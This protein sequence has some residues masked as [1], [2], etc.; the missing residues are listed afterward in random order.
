MLST[1]AFNALLKVLEEPPAHVVFILATTELHKIPATIISRCQRFD[2]RRVPLADIADH[3]TDICQKEKVQCEPEVITAI[4]KNSEGYL[5]DA[6][7][8]LGQILSLG[9]TKI[10]REHADLVLPHSHADLVLQFVATLVRRQAAEAIAL[11]DR[12]VQDGVNVPQFT[13]DTVELL[14]QILVAKITN[15]F[16]TAGMEFTRDEQRVLEDIFGQVSVE[17]LV[18]MIDTLLARSALFKT[19]PI[20]QLPLELAA[21]ELCTESQSNQP[22]AP[23][24]LPPPP[25]AK[26]ETTAVA[27][28]PKKPTVPLPPAVAAVADSTPAVVSVSPAPVGTVT[29]AAVREAWLPMSDELNDS[30]HSLSLILRLGKPL[31]MQGN[32]VMVGFQFPLHQ[33]I[34]ANAKN[35]L[36]V[37]ETLSSMLGSAV[38]VVPI[39]SDQAKINLV[40]SP[41]P[42]SSSLADIAAMVGGSVITN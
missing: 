38:V 22:P 19:S 15:S 34:V 31:Q 4:A 29:L 32:E 12:L 30:H 9:E 36:T 21:A 17:R 28:A 25:T 3:L 2:F 39:V 10:T 24:V 6:V 26:T 1:S 37:S 11:I 14:R 42:E 16:T 7:G 27:P 5:R 35:I 20:I 41:A 8:L 33:E 13:R 23:P 40:E 18:V